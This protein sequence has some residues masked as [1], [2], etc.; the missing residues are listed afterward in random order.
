[1]STVGESAANKAREAMGPAV[2]NIK[3]CG[4]NLEVLK[5]R[6]SRLEK[7][8]LCGKCKTFIRDN[9]G[10]MRRIDAIICDD[11]GPLHSSPAFLQYTVAA[12]IRDEL[13]EYRKTGTIKIYAANSSDQYLS[14]CMTCQKILEELFE[15]QVM[16][17][18]QAILTAGKD[19]GVMSFSTKKGNKS[20]KEV[21][22]LTEN[23]GGPAAILCHYTV[24]T[25]VPGV[26]VTSAPLKE[27][28]RKREE[29]K[30]WIPMNDS[31]IENELYNGGE[32]ATFGKLENEGGV[33]LYWAATD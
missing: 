5:E 1:M 6:K 31:L 15:I 2:M 14:Y 8:A 20:C 19:A 10:K 27:W 7:S 18:N 13:K 28:F 9:D 22:S 4:G 21:W 33:G 30:R 24:P 29:E 16:P 26:V 25:G 23:R 11:I 32:L 12:V 3:C 17:I